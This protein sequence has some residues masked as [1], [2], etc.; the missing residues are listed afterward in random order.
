MHRH[1]VSAREIARCTL[2]SLIRSYFDPTRVRL[3]RSSGSI[4]PLTTSTFDHTEVRLKSRFFALL[5]GSSRTLRP[6][7][8]STKRSGYVYSDLTPLSLRPHKG[9]SETIEKMMPSRRD[10]CFDPTRV[11]LKR[12]L[13]Q[14]WSSH[15]PSFD[16]TRVHLKPCYSD[17]VAS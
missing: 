17:A 3:K 16:P 11:H 1:A 8:G 9:P 14:S 7:R 4:R 15:H 13:L 5:P 6:R 2:C 10:A 12:Y